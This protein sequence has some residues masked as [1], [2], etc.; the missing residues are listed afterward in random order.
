MVDVTKNVSDRQW[1]RVG[2]VKQ[3]LEEMAGRPSAD[4]A[5]FIVREL[6]IDE[7]ERAWYEEGFADGL[8]GERGGSRKG[9]SNTKAMKTDILQRIEGLN[10]AVVHDVWG[11][12]PAVLEGLSEAIN[13]FMK[14]VSATE[15]D[16][17]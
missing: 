3:V 6:Q 5:V 8:T 17:P 7:I 10:Q 14:V 2:G 1:E 15:A 9:D 11:S 4:L 13:E 16:A 12:V